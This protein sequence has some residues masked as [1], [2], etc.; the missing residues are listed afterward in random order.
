VSIHF[1]CDPVAVV[2]SPEDNLASPPRSV[3]VERK[4]HI[5]KEHLGD[6][7]GIWN[8]LRYCFT[9]RLSKRAGDESWGQRRSNVVT[10]LPRRAGL[11]VLELSHG[12]YFNLVYAYAIAPF[13]DTVADPF[14]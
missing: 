1:L 5:R 2:P 10:S 7:H 13:D 14:P 11:R 4:D 12:P 8:A 6:E 9:D 3:P